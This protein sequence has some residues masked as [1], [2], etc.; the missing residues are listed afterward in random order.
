MQ[1]THWGLIP[2]SRQAGALNPVN[3]LY[4]FSHPKYPKK[5]RYGSRG[6]CREE[7]KKIKN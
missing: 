1:V 3:T 4:G 6:E 5:P 2:Q 7:E